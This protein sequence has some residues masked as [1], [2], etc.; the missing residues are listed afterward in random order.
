V[1]AAEHRHHTT[2]ADSELIAR[3]LLTAAVTDTQKFAAALADLGGCPACTLSVL[4]QLV[5]TLCGFVFDQEHHDDFEEPG[6]SC[7]EPIAAEVLALRLVLC[8]SGDNDHFGV[9][10]ALE[11]VIYCQS[12]LLEVLFAFVTA[13]ITILEGTNVAWRPLLER[14]LMALLDEAAA[15]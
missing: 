3:R 15:Q 5:Y 7:E 12:C 8:A 4:A 6:C 9:A 10:N 11:H 1:V 2:A 13:H 14:Q